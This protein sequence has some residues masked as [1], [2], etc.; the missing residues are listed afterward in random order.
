MKPIRFITA[1]FFLT[2]CAFSMSAAA[3]PI[4]GGKTYFRK[5]HTLQF[6]N[7]WRVVESGYKQDNSGSRECSYHFGDDFTLW[8]EEGLEVFLVCDGE[9]TRY[10]LSPESDYLSRSNG[11]S[12]ELK[13]DKPL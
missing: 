3:E 7:N 12:Y 2:L 10:I 1:S 6:K 4:L 13:D 8:E 5:E 11:Y 9:V